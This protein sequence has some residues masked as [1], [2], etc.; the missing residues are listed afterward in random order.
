MSQSA[1]ILSTEVLV[2]VIS[3]RPALIRL[4]NLVAPIAEEPIPASHAKTIFLISVD[5]SIVPGTTASPFA[6]AFMAAISFWASSRL[7]SPAIFTSMEAMAKEIPAEITIPI[8]T[9][10]ISGPGAI[11]I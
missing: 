9:F 11:I 5:F 4:R 10:S 8:S 3:G 2:T 7:L 1:G 6:W